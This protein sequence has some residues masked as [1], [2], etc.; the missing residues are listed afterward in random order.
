MNPDR[1]IELCPSLWHVGPEGSW[2]GI[3]R[4][5]FRT[6]AQLIRRADL[7][8]ERAAELWTKPRPE[9]VRLTVDGAPVV[10]RDQ[11][12]LF[13]KKDAASILGDGTDAEDWVRILNSRMY[14]FAERAP[15]E[16]FRDRYVQRDGAQDVL[17]ISPWRLVQT[18][19]SRVQLAS[20]NTA[21]IARKAG[22]QKE[23][24]TFSSVV[25]FPNRR[26]KEVTVIDGLDDLSVV[27]RAERHYADGRREVLP[28]PV[29]DPES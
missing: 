26:P 9:S 3:V 7:D 6:A 14:L 12:P 13:R 19:G 2:D 15:M 20:Q 10:L 1:F 27:T 25:A 8:E 18:A 24:E 5:G 21:A 22:V 16:T 23:H 17:T 4:H 28:L 11:E 29:P